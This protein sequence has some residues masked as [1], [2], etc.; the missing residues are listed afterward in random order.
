M[1]PLVYIA[2]A[3]AVLI[4]LAIYRWA[5]VWWAVPFYALAIAAGYGIG[6]EVV[7]WPKA[8]HYEWR[9]VDKAHVLGARVVEDQA[10]Y[11]WLGLPDTLAPRAYV[12]P[13][14]ANLARQLHE[15]REAAADG[16]GI[17]MRKPFQGYETDGPMFY[18]TPQEPEQLKDGS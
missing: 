13:Y 2:S 9:A 5:K 18:P 3:V 7:G 4:G 8:L 17:V 10:I 16:Q 1:S 11:L 15:A 14:D 6:F 12:M